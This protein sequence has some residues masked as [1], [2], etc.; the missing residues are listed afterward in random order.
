MITNKWLMSHFEGNLRLVNKIHS[1]GHE[2]ADDE[3]E[4]K[5]DLGVMASPAPAPLAACRSTS[6]IKGGDASSEFFCFQC[7]GY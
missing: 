2:Y 5:E 6:G 4:Y 7:G 3:S 1:S